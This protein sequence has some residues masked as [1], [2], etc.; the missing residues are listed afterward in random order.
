[1]E[2]T[3]AAGGKG[4]NLLKARLRVSD[5]ARVSADPVIPANAVASSRAGSLRRRRADDGENDI[6]NT[7]GAAVSRRGAPRMRS[8]EVT[9]ASF[10]CSLSVSGTAGCWEGGRQADRGRGRDRGGRHPFTR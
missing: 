6:S 7:L 2:H 3:L 9:G 4:L 1:M 8:V 5:I 10:G